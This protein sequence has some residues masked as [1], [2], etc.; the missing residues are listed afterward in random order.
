[1]L[2]RSRVFQRTQGRCCVCG[3]LA[4]DAHHI[5][6]RK[7]FRDGGYY[8]SNGA[9]VCEAHHWECETTRIPVPDIRSLARV[10]Q[11]VVPDGLS[12]EVEIDKWGNVVLANEWTGY[13]VAGPL[14]GD[15]G[16]LRA[17]ASGGV[18]RLL[19]DQDPITYTRQAKD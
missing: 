9:P 12:M 8:I 4:V 16:M 19:L 10:A 7:L 15:A 1:M 6:E 14:K 11:R 18:R 13:R 2:F 3:D 5:L 17:L